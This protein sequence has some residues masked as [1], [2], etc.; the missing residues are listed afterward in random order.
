MS[1]EQTLKPLT[2]EVNLML[3]EK[4]VIARFPNIGQTIKIEQQKQIL[5]DGRYAIM[6]YAGLKTTTAMLDIVDAICYLS[7]VIPNF[8]KAI[9]VSS[10]VELLE[11]DMDSNI[12]IE[13]MNEYNEKYVPFYNDLYE[14]TDR[15]SSAVKK[16]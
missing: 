10:H 5:T 4:S 11:M 6:A 8:Y 14:R 3:R 9:G 15:P 12:I 16:D 1:E 13:M 2:K 7:N